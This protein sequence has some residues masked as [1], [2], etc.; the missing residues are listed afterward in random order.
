M[1][2]ILVLS[3]YSN[4]Y[5]FYTKKF[6][7]EESCVNSLRQFVNKLENGDPSNV[8]SVIC[9]TQTIFETISNDN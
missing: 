5:G 7:S 6:D 3:L 9:M 8:K 1:E 2:W 4:P